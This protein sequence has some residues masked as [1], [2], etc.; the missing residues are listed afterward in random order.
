MSRFSDF[1]HH[2]TPE[3]REKVFNDVIDKANAR[4]RRLV[5]KSYE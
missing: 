2:A 3:E 5:E 1:F 4:Q